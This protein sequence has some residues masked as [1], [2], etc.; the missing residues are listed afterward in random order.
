MDKWK[1]SLIGNSLFLQR[2]S[3]AGDDLCG[4]DDL[5]P[6][7]WSGQQ[8]FKESFSS[9]YFFSNKLIHLL[10]QIFGTDK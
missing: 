1:G 7:R 4:E 3:A 5:K 2:Y 9:S 8:I 10:P 6:W